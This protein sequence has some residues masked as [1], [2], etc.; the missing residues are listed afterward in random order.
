MSFSDVYHG[1]AIVSLD[2]LLLYS[3]KPLASSYSF[4]L[5]SGPPSM[6]LV[7]LGSAGYFWAVRVEAYPGRHL[8]LV[9]GRKL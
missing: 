5:R 4:I 6:S 7:R 9:V 8:C 3:K 2:F 1:S